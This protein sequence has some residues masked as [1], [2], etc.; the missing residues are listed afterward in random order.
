MKLDPN[1]IS[2]SLSSDAQIVPSSGPSPGVWEYTPADI[3]RA[4]VDICHGDQELADRLVIEAQK[5]VNSVSVKFDGQAVTAK[6]AQVVLGPPKSSGESV[7][8]AYA[9]RIQ[10]TGAEI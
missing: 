10:E 5:Q 3:R 4:L 7:A 8:R 1:L 9:L 6:E 2:P